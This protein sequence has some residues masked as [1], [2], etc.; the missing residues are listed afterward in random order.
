MALAAG[1]FLLLAVLAQPGFDNTRAYEGTDTRAGALLAGAALA[2]VYRPRARDEQLQTRGR[3]TVD[4][5]GVLALGVIVWMVATTTEY[6]MGMY[7]G[8][9]LALTVATVVLVAVAVHP[10]SLVARALG[11][12]SLALGRRA[13]LRHLSVAHAGGGVRGTGRLRGVL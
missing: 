3:I 8:G 12:G 6:A 10:T 5:A 2:L 11:R 1:S 7:R 9:L 13:L 4:A